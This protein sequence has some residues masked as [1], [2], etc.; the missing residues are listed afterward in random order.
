M[1]TLLVSMSI[2]AALLTAGMPASASEEL[3][4]TSGC[5]TCH[6][7]DKKKMGPALKAAGAAFKKSGADADKVAAAIKAK[8]PD[9]KASA[10]D[11]KAIGGWILTL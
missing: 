4:K 1:R 6:A 8:H 10:A 7:V 3:A 2:G 11:L 5:L 9:T